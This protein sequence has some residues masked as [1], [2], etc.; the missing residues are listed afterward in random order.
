MLI[1]PRKRDTF[2]ERSGD[3]RTLGQ[4]AGILRQGA[5]LDALSD[6]FERR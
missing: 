2:P 5:N 1:F 3:P 4:E 6:Y